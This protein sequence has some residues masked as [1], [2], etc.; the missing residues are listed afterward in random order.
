MTK[1]YYCNMDNSVFS[2]EEELIEHIKKNY[3][4][5]FEGKNH[6]VSN[7][8]ASLQNDFPDWEIHIKEGSGWY[9]QYIIELTKDGST[10][11]Q[12]YGNVKNDSY[13]NQDKPSQYSD[14]VKEIRD[15]ISTYTNILEKVKTLYSFTEFKFSSYTYGYS[16][17][18]HSYCFNF[19]VNENDAW[20]SEEFYHYENELDDFIADLK[21]YFIRVVE[22][23]PESFYDGGYFAD[24]TID[25]VKIGLMMNKKKVRLEVLEE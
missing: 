11:T 22:G 18:E 24:Y 15:K 10:I 20:D 13:Y 17:D 25:G 4:K 3:V 21:K 7:L 23:K 1:Q 5:V 9:S 8:L 6:A 19:K 12:Y 2:T 16:T 14:V